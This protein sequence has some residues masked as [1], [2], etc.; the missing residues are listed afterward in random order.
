MMV[1][2]LYR[3]QAKKHNT[4]RTGFIGTAIL[5]VLWVVLSLFAIPCTGAEAA[6]SREDICGVYSISAKM[7]YA[8]GHG[9]MTIRLRGNN[10]TVSYGGEDLSEY[11]H[12]SFNYNPV[13][14]RAEVTFYNDKITDGPYGPGVDTAVLNFS[15]SGNNITLTGTDGLFRLSGRRIRAIAAEPGAPVD[16][17]QS[18]QSDPQK[19]QSPAKPGANQQKDT[20]KQSDSDT[21]NHDSSDND[22]HSQQQ[23]SE[24]DDRNDLPESD[25]GKT[26][27][28]VGTGMGE[29]AW[30]EPC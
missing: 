29:L 26:A 8:T 18:K 16:K 4:F 22:G 17:P 23:D 9:T 12:R 1:S 10:Y 14:G 11:R 30:G 24:Y 19:N 28:A 25:A 7:E 3:G 20:T 15:G 5:T 2:N 6:P 27:A 21:G 13:T